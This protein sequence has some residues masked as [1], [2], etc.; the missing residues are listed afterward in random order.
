MQRYTLRKKLQ[1]TKGPVNA[2]VFSNDGVLL[3]SGGEIVSLVVFL[4]TKPIVG[5]DECVR[6]WNIEDFKCEQVLY[7]PKWGQITTLTWISS[8][9]QIDQRINSIC[10]GTGRGFVGLFPMSNE[11]MV[12][13]RWRLRR[14]VA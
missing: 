3:L 8:E 7:N 13:W 2:L 10:V 6:V 12:R 5:D 4:Q 11:S 1:G 9:E 14:L